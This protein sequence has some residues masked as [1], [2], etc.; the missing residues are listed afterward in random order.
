MAFRM[1][2][3]AI[4]VLEVMFFTGLLGC[5]VAVILSWISVG[6]GCF[7]DEK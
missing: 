2:E 1:A 4:R 3:L 6:Q 5:A 7:T